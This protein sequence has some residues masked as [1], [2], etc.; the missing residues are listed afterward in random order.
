VKDC[1]NLEKNINL[2]LKEN[3][4]NLGTVA[5]IDNPSYFGGGDWEDH[6]SRA[7]LAKSS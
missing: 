1:P 3:Q 7:A 5:H 2:Q 4:A 6:S